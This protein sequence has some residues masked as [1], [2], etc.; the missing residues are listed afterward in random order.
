MPATDHS[1]KFAY[2]GL[3]EMGGPMVRTQPSLPSTCIKFD[4]AC[5]FRRKICRTGWQRTTTQIRFWCGTG[6]VPKLTSLAE[7]K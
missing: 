3:G 1:L 2:V 4:Q 5:F 6:R 7:S